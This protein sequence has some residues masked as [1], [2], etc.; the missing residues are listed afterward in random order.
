MSRRGRTRLRIIC[1]DM[2]VYKLR[3]FTGSREYFKAVFLIDP[4][5]TYDSIFERPA[6]R[7]EEL[8]LIHEVFERSGVVDL[9]WVMDAPAR[10]RASI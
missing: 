8:E 9:T 7:D 5:F 6:L 10:W 4:D 2:P 1:S 3:E